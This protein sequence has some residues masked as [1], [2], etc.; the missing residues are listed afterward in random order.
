[1]DLFLDFLLYS[2]DLY[3]FPF[4]T[5]LV[6]FAPCQYAEVWLTILLY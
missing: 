3:V 6:P 1:M 5:I 4:T 2:I